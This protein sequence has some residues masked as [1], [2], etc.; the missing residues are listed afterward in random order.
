VNVNN[1]FAG[2]PEELQATATALC[3][4]DGQQRALSSVLFE[5]LSRLEHYWQ[6]LNVEGFAAIRE[7]WQERALLT[8]RTVTVQVG[9][10]LHTGRCLGIDDA[11]QLLL[12][13]ET[14]RQAFAAGSVLRFE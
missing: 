4:L 12:Q 2:A 13:T 5:I 10:A 8:G 7:E 3:D 9:Q 1:S 14:G 6:R 11:G